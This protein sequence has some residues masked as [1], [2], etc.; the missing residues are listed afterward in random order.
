MPPMWS[1][2]ASTAAPGARAAPSRISAPPML[3]ECRLLRAEPATWVPCPCGSLRL[4]GLVLAE[5]VEL[6]HA[7]GKRGM[8]VVV[9]PLSKPVSATAMIS[10]S[11]W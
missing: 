5:R 3:V 4:A 6:G 2:R 9:E 10:P 7:A 11:P 1:S 8:D